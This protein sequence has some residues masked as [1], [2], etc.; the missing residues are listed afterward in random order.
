MNYSDLKD[1]I[2]NKILRLNIKLHPDEITL[3][4]SKK[5]RLKIGAKGKKYAHKF[6]TPNV[7]YKTI[8]KEST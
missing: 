8:I 2:L 6:L 7:A 1:F 3:I 4:K 5:L